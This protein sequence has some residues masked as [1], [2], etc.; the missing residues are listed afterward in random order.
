MSK[1]TREPIWAALKNY[2]KLHLLSDNYYPM[3]PVQGLHFEGQFQIMLSFDLLL[4]KE[5]FDKL[6]GLGINLSMGN[7]EAALYAFEVLNDEYFGTPPQV[8]VLQ[9]YPAFL[10]LQR[11]TKPSI[12]TSEERK[13][14]LYTGSVSQIKDVL[15]HYKFNINH[16]ANTKESGIGDNRLILDCAGRLYNIQYTV[17]GDSDAVSKFAQTI[18]EAIKLK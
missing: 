6:R 13:L 16:L 18:D 15:R 9:T 11:D 1:E 2:R 3:P 5:R 14:N 7:L 8:G 12:V 4:E 17:S 10:A